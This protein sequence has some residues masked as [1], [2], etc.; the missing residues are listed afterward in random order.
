MLKSMV[1]RPVS[2]ALEQA[3]T[4]VIKSAAMEETALSNILKLEKTIIQKAKRV[5]HNIEE[6]VSINESVNGI[7]R[8]ITKLQMLMQIKL[9][10][11]EELLQKISCFY[12][13][14][15]P[16]KPSAEIMDVDSQVELEE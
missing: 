10:D 16:E 14:D 3:I 6:F 5:S 9:Q 4:V 13:I 1:N 8:N 12:E 15:N 11:A 7:I 2:A